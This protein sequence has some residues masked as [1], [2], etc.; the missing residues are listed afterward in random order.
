[1][2]VSTSVLMSQQ[3]ANLKQKSSERIVHYPFTE[4]L[5]ALQLQGNV[6][7]PVLRYLTPL[8]DATSRCRWTKLATDMV[9]ILNST[10]GQP[11]R[12]GLPSQRL[13]KY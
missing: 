6:L 1:M 12:S 7:L 4:H 10:R 8:A 11:I 13:G 9:N 5:T 2:K 3:L